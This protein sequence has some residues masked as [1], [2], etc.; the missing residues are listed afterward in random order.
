M[1][2]EATCVC[3]PKCITWCQ[4]LSYHQPAGAALMYGN[5]VT[6]GVWYKSAAIL[7]RIPKWSEFRRKLIAISTGECCD[8]TGA[9]DGIVKGFRNILYNA[10]L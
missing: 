2:G 10:R 8:I 3:K 7:I 1:F 5:E 9:E 4:K 6:L